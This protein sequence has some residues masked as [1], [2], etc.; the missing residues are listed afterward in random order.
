MAQEIQFWDHSKRLNWF[1][2][3]AVARKILEK[4][5]ILRDMQEWVESNWANDPSKQRSLRLWRKA[6]ILA[7]EC[8]VTAV[9]ADTP[10]AQETRESPPPFFVLTAKERVE[11]IKSSREEAA[12]AC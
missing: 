4:P 5:T 10:D 12:V 2:M 9:L 8:F 7:P 6:L 3:R 1:M 11:Y